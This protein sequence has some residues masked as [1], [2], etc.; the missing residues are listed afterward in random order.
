[1]VSIRLM[2]IPALLI[3]SLGFS[4]SAWPQNPQA[5]QDE[6]ISF[7]KKNPQ[8]EESAKGQHL[9]FSPLKPNGNQTFLVLDPDG[10][11]PSDY[12]RFLAPVDELDKQPKR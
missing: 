10:K 1:M 6:E 12:E 8:D 5:R 7:P 11:S 4:H 2:A 3:F 9:F